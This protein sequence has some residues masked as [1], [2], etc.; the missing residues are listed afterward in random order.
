M[1]V[2]LALL[3]A[4]VLK[5]YV[6]EAYEIHG[7]SMMDT[8][9]DDQRVMLLKVFYEIHRGDIII[10]S[11]SDNPQKDLI[12]RVIGLPGD[13]VVVNRSDVYVNGQKLREPYAVRNNKEDQTASRWGRAS[14]T[15]W[16]TTV[17]TA[18][19]AAASTPLTPPPSRARSSCAG[20]PWSVW[21]R[22]DRGRGRRPAARP[23]L[24][25]D[26]EGGAMAAPVTGRVTAAAQGESEFVL[27]PV[28]HLLPGKPLPFS[29][30]RRVEGEHIL[31]RGAGRAL[32]ARER[33]GILQNHLTGLYISP[34]DLPRYRAY[35]DGV[36]KDLILSREIGPGRKVEAFYS[37]AS[38]IGAEV[39]RTPDRPESVASASEVV[40]GTLALLDGGKEILHLLMEVMSGDFD[41]VSHAI[42]VTNY[43]LALARAAGIRKSSDLLEMGLGLFLHDVGLR[44]VP[45]RILRKRGPLSFEERCVLQR[46][47]QLGVDLFQPLGLLPEASI[48]IIRDHHERCDGSGYPAGIPAERIS[49][50]AAHRRHRLRLRRADHEQPLPAVDLLLRGDPR[51]AQGAPPGLRPRPPEGL[52]PDHR[53]GPPPEGRQTLTAGAGMGEARAPRTP[54]A[55]RAGTAAAAAPRRP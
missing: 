16:E 53:E 44:L 47:P 22:S 15:S 46:H 25:V 50:G 2:L 32:E 4:L 42:N 51:H 49:T 35:M 3:L 24:P 12:K 27:V 48:A 33:E 19:T 14:T 41:L 5:V 17:P 31:F 8:F 20:G 6:A 39:M 21:A 23:G 45:E 30:Y 37:L 10:F 54:P 18:R 11:S 40:Q 34:A 43:G 1:V 7:R 28:A 36:L 55:A 9:H 52:H 29:L 38:G 13:T 26:R